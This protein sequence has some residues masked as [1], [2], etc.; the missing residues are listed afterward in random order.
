VDQ[1]SAQ[2]EALKT[3]SHP[4]IGRAGAEGKKIMLLY[5]FTAGPYLRGISKHGLTVGDVPTDIER[6]KGKIGVWLTTSESASNHGLEGSRNTKGQYRLSVLVPDDSPLLAKWTQ[7]APQ[8]VTAKSVEA[9]HKS[10][11]GFD[12]WYVYFGVIRAD[13]I[14]G[15]VD[16]FTGSNIEDW[17]EVSPRELDVPAVPPWRRDAWQRGMLSE[18]KKEAN[19]RLVELG[20]KTKRR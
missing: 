2:T 1:G 12:T 10:A 18:V 5:H 19:R 14:I 9:L 8:N 16:T 6:S 13:A 4:Q 15:C 7:W 3:G 20:L 11:A 17:G